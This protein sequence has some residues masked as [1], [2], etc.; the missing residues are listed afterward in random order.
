MEELL[1]GA[2]VY[3]PGE[4]PPGFAEA[5]GEENQPRIMLG[6][7]EMSKI[8]RH[9]A[10]I[11]QQR[12]E[13]RMRNIPLHVKQYIAPESEFTAQSQEIP[14]E[15]KRTE[16]FS[17][18]E[19]L[20]AAILRSPQQG[21]ISY[22][23]LKHYDAISVALDSFDGEYMLLEEVDWEFLKNRLEQFKWAQYSRFLLPFVNDIRNAEQA[24]IELVKNIPE[25]DDIPL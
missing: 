5:M 7:E 9:K 1:P 3:P 8:N 23:E 17:Y 24:K 6:D 2:I 19:I 20:R 14:S 15:E 11:K 21:G 25:P 13:G 18:R 22:A 4:I 12:E 16:K 10:K